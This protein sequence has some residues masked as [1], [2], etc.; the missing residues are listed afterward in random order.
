M[1]K[2]GKYIYGIINSKVEETFDLDGIGTLEDSYRLGRP[3]GLVSVSARHVMKAMPLTDEPSL[4]GKDSIFCSQAHTISFQDI[5]AVVSD[6]E[7]VDYSGM[8]KDILAMRLL[9]H[10]EVIEKIMAEHTIIPMRLGTFAESEQGVSRILSR[11]YKTIKDIFEMAKN[12]IEIDVVAVLSDFNSFLQEVSEQEEIK[13]LKQSLLSK[14]GGVTVDDQ[15]QVGVLIK[16]HLDRKREEYA[17]QIQKALGRLVRGLKA[18]DLMDDKMVLNMAFLIG[19]NRQKDF[20]HEVDKLN[21]EFLEKL[22]FRCVGPLPPY[23]F[24]TLEVKR[25][26]F[27][28]IDWARKRLGLTNDF[29]TAGDIKKAHRRVALTCHPDKNPDTPGI[30]KKFDDMTRAYKILLDYYRS[31]NQTEQ[32]NGCYFNE[33]AFENSA[34]LVTTAE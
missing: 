21:N 24:Y 31:S 17:A 27:E 33:E 18:H 20:E 11:G 12:T 7:V 9:R 8:P 32:T 29:I 30:E 22:N 1:S 16:K 15:M 19:Q 23:S 4:D 13:Q 5:S 34:M 26:R 3:A 6:A 28:E 14:D 25:S 2:V 10:Q